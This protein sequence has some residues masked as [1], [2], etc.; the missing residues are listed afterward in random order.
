MASIMTTLTFPILNVL[1]TEYYDVEVDISEVQIANIGVALYDNR[2]AVDDFQI[3]AIRA[4]G[5]E[6]TFTQEDIWAHTAQA[7]D[8]IER[9][10]EKLNDMLERGDFNGYDDTN[11]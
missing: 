10:L 8:M 2:Q 3:D 1:G 6:V 9:V 7:Q 11:E 5:D 4:E